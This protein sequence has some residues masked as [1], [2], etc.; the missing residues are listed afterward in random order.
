MSTNEFLKS[1]DPEVMIAATL[2]QASV[3]PMRDRAHAAHHQRPTRMAS[4]LAESHDPPDDVVFEDVA[5]YEQDGAT[6][7]V[8]G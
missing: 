7:N 8:P 1:P 6:S 5:G 4:A 2:A 3:R